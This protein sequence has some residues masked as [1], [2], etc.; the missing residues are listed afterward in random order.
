MLI[1]YHVDVNIW[2]GAR[3]RP[4]DF[5]MLKNMGI[6]VVLNLESGMYEKWHRDE[7]REL[8]LCLMSGMENPRLLMSDFFPPTWDELLA[9]KL[10]LRSGKKVYVHC[11][12][13]V[14]RTGVVIADYRVRVE[15]WPVDRAI[16]EMYKF[17]FHRLWYWWWIPILKWRWSRWGHL[18]SK[19]Q[20]S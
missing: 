18:F 20:P 8:G 6:Q 12:H 17:G 5:V 7:G 9:S 11:L 3:P 13:G 16:E 1:P 10:V 2:R 15:N 14:D 19:G 4:R